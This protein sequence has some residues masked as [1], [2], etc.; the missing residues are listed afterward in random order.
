LF[1]QAFLPSHGAV[2]FPPG[3][4]DRSLATLVVDRR[5]L[6]F[7]GVTRGGRAEPDY[8][9]TLDVPGLGP[10]SLAVVDHFLLRAAELGGDEV[11]ARLRELERIVGQMG[12]RIAVRVGLTR[13][14]APA[15][16]QSAPAVCW[17]MADGFFS[18]SDP[19]S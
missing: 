7:S 18:L 1:G 11:T 14:F 15:G 9:V 13:P 4:G 2:S 17:L 12:E 5:S 8:R 16:G 19:Q 10:R 3:G 6:T